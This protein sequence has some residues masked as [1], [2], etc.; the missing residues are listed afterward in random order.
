MKTC[1]KKRKKE[2]KRKKKGWGGRDGE[3]GRE[4]LAGSEVGD[5]RGI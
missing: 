1:K 4:K 5:S 3:R 2:E